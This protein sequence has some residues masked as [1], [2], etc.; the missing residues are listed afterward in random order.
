M[1]ANNRSNYVIALGVILCSAA[2]LGALSFAL[3]GFAIGAAGR[4]VAIDFRDATGIKLHSMVKYAGKTAGTVTDIRYL[5]PEEQKDGNVVRVIAK[6]DE[7]VP[8]L[9][10]NVKASLTAETLL[11][12]KFIALQPG[13][14]GG[15]ALADG[16]VIQ[17]G[18][19]ASIDAVAGSAQ[20]AI[21][22]VTDILKKVQADYPGLVPR[23][24]EIL[25]QG[26]SILSQGSNLVNHV[27]ATVLNADDAVT[28]L[29]ADYKELVPKLSA[30]FAEAQS[31]GTNADHAVLKA[32]ALLERLDGVV[33]TNQADLKKTLEELRVTSQNLKVITTYAKALTA[34]LAQKPSSLIW[35]RKRNELP[36]ERSILESDQPVPARP[37]D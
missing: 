12:E 7:E 3:T 26:S 11:G 32:S 1:K 19:V 30:L 28:Q 9:L 16:A 31:I 22:T 8:P 4:T 6:L 27:D 21:Q 14:A 34:T 18:D 23:L 15:R 17:G 25:K 33:V 20:E 13:D 36:D 35:G 2:L 29:R 10:D 37:A 5:R 24:A